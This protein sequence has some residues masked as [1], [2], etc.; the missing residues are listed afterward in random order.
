MELAKQVEKESMESDQIYQLNACRVVSQI[1][2]T[3]RQLQ[4]EVHMMGE[5]PK[6]II[7]TWSGPPRLG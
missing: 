3:Q 5:T 7:T 2:R 4:K 1:T 6:R